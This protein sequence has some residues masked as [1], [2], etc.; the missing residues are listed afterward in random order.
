MNPRVLVIIAIIVFLG[1]GV[2]LMLTPPKPQVVVVKPAQN[3]T[4]VAPPVT[5]PVVGCTENLYVKIWGTEICGGTI[6]YMEYRNNV[7]MLYIE[8]VS[9]RGK[10]I[11][12]DSGCTVVPQLN[13]WIKLMCKSYIIITQ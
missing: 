12:Q 11:L 3:Q 1:Y 10:F 4:T 13:G 5:Q 2:Y 9:V 7:Y 8:N 6:Y